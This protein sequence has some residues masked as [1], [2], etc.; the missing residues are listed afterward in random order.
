MGDVRYQKNALPTIVALTR[1]LWF[2]FE[3]RLHNSDWRLK[4]CP[5]ALMV[6]RS[7]LVNTPLL[8]VT[9]PNI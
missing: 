3:L 7:C 8:I 5:K 2:S 4:R 9:F 6:C 1:D